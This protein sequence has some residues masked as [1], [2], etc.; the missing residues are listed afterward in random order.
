LA[1]VSFINSLFGTRHPLDSPV[2][3]LNTEQIGKNL[4]KQQPDEVVSIEGKIYVIEEQT[5]PDRN[6][7]IR[8][9]EYGY[10]QALRDK[11][12]KDGVIALPFPRMIV[13]YLEVGTVTP[14]VL[15]VRLEFPDGAGHDFNVKTLKLLDCGVEELAAE[16]L[17]SLLP[18]YMVKLRKEAKR[19]R[20]E[21]DRRRVEEAFREL[22]VK[23]AKVIE[24]SAREWPLDEADITTLL[25]RLK[26][27][28]EYVGKGYRTAE[29]KEMID[30][31][32][33]GYGKV[34]RMEGKQEGRLEVLN[35]IKA[36]CS[37]EALKE[38]L[39]AELAAAESGTQTRS[40]QS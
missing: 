3:R 1:L 38:R 21:E 32:L 22:G 39:E 6:M 14:D 13:I 19:A 29:V 31:S 5:G 25:E 33:M 18:F 34:L 9:F 16:G 23:L 12:V 40:P 37:T 35:L 2:V 15:T 28:V 27:I 17:A 36:G 30:R 24:G 8:V 10:A 20:K 26:G 4:Q 7:A 11:T